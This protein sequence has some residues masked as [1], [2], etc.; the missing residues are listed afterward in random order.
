M[1]TTVVDPV[2]ASQEDCVDIIDVVTL[3]DSLVE[4]AETFM[5]S[6][7]SPDEFVRFYNQPT[8][9]E[10]VDDD[11]ECNDVY[12][13]KEREMLECISLDHGLVISELDDCEYI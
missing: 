10:I 8:I 11:C 2:T 7:S 9:V 1:K 3:S 4:G 6:L 5:I 13:D 12:V